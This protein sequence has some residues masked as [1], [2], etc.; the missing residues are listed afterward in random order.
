[1]PICH[2]YIIRNT[3]P[4]LRRGG[5]GVGS[6]VAAGPQPQSWCCVF[7][8]DEEGCTR[9]REWFVVAENWRRARTPAI[10]PRYNTSLNVLEWYPISFSVES[11]ISKSKFRVK[12]YDIFFM[13]WPRLLC[14]TMEVPHLCETFTYYR[15][16]MT[17]F[18]KSEKFH[19]IY[20]FSRKQCF[21]AP[22]GL[23][24]IRLVRLL[25]F[26]RNSVFFSKHFSQNSVFS[27]FQLSFSKPNED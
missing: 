24:Y 2:A 8:L 18:V 19:N 1:M 22:F 21:S 5:F 27:H 23:P 7:S 17:S 26:S 6:Q 12:S 10:P 25:F 9:T 11:K 13:W 15:F 14:L 20:T 16:I 4:V 3:A